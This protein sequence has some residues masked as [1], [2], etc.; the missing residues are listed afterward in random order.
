MPKNKA[1]G[2]MALAVIAMLV[3]HSKTHL[4]YIRLLPSRMRISEQCRLGICKLVQA[5]A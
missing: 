3:D 5:F 4:L 2:G 1:V